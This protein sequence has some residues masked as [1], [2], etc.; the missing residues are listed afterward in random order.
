MRRSAAQCKTR[1]WPYE[2]AFDSLKWD[3]LI[4]ALN[5]FN[6]C[7]SFKSRDETFYI[8][9]I[10]SCVTNNGSST[11]YFPFKRAVRQGDPLSPYLLIIGLELLAIHIRN[12]KEIN[13]LTI[14]KEEVKVVIF[15][16]DMPRFLKIKQSYH[17]LVT[18]KSKKI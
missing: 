15:A 10:S 13:G 7:P 5:A 16:G 6:F 1:E 12:D 18:E 9:N 17:S 3:Y 14:G 2:K 11:S 8:K 4:G